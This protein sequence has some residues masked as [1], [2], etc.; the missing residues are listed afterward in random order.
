MLQCFAGNEELTHSIVVTKILLFEDLASIR[1]FVGSTKTWL[2][3]PAHRNA[4]EV[5]NH[6]CNQEDDAYIQTDSLK[7][8][9]G[10]LP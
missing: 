2:Q 4:L 5:K 1:N 8:E 10:T 9:S 6:S 3:H 7:P